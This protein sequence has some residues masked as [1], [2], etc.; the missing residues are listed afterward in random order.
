MYESLDLDK[1]NIF[2][3]SE[4][5]FGILVFSI[6]YTPGTKFFGEKLGNF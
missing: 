1:T 3:K 5:P 6:K 4:R 2:N